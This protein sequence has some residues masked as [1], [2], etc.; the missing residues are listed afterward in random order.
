MTIGTIRF[1]LLHKV[2]IVDPLPHHPRD[3][4]AGQLHSA[5]FTLYKSRLSEIFELQYHPPHP[6]S[7][8]NLRPHAEEGKVKE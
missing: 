7:P 4:S 2:A 1:L 6:V 3:L 8:L 5:L